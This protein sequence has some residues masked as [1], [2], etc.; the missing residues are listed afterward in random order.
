MAS[1]VEM[2]RSFPTHL[3]VSYTW[4]RRGTATP[5]TGLNYLHNTS[6]KGRKSNHSPLKMEPSDAY[7]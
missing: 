2:D 7:K 4:A 3:Y 5:A 1:G 6:N